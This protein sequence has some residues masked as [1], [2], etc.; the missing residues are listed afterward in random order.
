[1]K[2]KCIT[3][4]KFKSTLNCYHVSDYAVHYN[5]RAAKPFEPCRSSKK[6]ICNCLN[7]KKSFTVNWAIS[8][9]WNNIQ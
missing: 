3:L 7:F 5:L 6:G 9:N 8:G 2:S 1:M 4:T